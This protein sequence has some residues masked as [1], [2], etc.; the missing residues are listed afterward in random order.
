MAPANIEISEWEEEAGEEVVKS[1]GGELKE[2]ST[3]QSNYF[4]VRPY[5][6]LAGGNKVTMQMKVKSGDVTIYHSVDYKNWEEV[7]NV[8]IED[9]VAKFKYHKGIKQG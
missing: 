2:G 1:Q 4:I 5:E 6:T 3:Y 8:E 7:S 9:N